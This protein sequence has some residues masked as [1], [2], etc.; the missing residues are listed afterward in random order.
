M[1]IDFFLFITFKLFSNLSQSLR[2]CKWREVSRSQFSAIWVGTTIKNMKYIDYIDIVINCVHYFIYKYCG[3]SYLM[4]IYPST[5]IYSYK[6]YL[7]YAHLSQQATRSASIGI[8]ERERTLLS[9]N[10]RNH[11]WR[12]KLG[13]RCKAHFGGVEF[14]IVLCVGTER[15]CLEIDVSHTTHLCD[16]EC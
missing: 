13:S 4:R 14:R 1:L 12:T 7:R 8:V 11:C 2:Y 16:K 6:S 15:F 10:N 3:Y 9:I 5:L